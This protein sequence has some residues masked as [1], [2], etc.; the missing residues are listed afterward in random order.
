V[1]RTVIN[2]DVPFKTS[3]GRAVI[4]WNGF[5]PVAGTHSISSISKLPPP[6]FSNL[7]LIS[8]KLFGVVW[9]LGDT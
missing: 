2:L 7:N 1:K 3:C 4:T 5:A 6:R 9:L 8:W